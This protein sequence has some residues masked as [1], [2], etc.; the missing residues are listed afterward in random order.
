[1]RIHVLQHEPYEGPGLIHE[2]ANERGY[3][4]S[5]TEVFNNQPLPSTD[6]FDC[7]VIMGGAMSVNDES[8]YAWLKP[9]KEL[10]RQTVKADKLILGI[11]LGAQMI[12]SAL[13]KAVYKN[14]KKEIG[15]FPVTLTQAGENKL[16]SGW[17]N[18]TF[19]HWHGETFDLPEGAELL[20]S[21]SACLNQAFIIGQKIWA[22]QFHPEV[23]Q[24]VLHQMVSS[25]SAELIKEEFIMTPDEVLQQ[26]PIIQQ[27]RP[28][29]FNLL[30]KI[31]N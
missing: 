19:F 8:I 15:W 29:L 4:V 23:N 10:V 24:Q 28:L 26:E 12:A 31:I 3:I 22:F 18:Q 25:G 13:G 16:S 5:I 1:M 6:L 27:T 30:D 14:G 20:A 11:C 21:S 9:E 7:L 17:H 2:W